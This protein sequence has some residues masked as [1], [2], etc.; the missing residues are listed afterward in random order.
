MCCSSAVFQ[1][2]WRTEHCPEEAHRNI[3]KMKGFGV[4]GLVVY[5][6]S[7]VRHH[8]GAKYT[9]VNAQV[10]PSLQQTCNKAGL[11]TYTQDM[12]AV[13]SPCSLTSCYQVVSTNLA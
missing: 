7:A 1:L 13:S 4:S 2:T 5:G 8:E 12:F 11:T 6:M 10:V 9:H 3:Y